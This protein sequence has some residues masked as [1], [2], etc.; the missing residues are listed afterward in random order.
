MNR[1][2]KIVTIVGLVFFVWFIVFF[3]RYGWDTNQV[4]LTMGII[5][6]IFIVGGLNLMQT[7]RKR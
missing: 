5:G 2:N 4:N 6:S 7:G 3:I 1:I